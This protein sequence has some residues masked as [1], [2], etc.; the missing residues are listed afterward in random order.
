[1]KFNDDGLLLPN[2]FSGFGASFRWTFIQVYFNSHCFILN[3]CKKNIWRTIR[4]WR[5]VN[6][7]WLIFEIF[8]YNYKRIEKLTY[9]NYLNK[10][11]NRVSWPFY[12]FAPSW[13]YQQGHICSIYDVIDM[14]M[15]Y[16]IF[17]FSI[18]NY[19]ILNQTWY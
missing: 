17:P 2:M 9:F 7:H 4:L 18:F 10:S 1:M 14:I 13:W 8:N 6:I 5:H 3:V 12:F 15:V 11:F 16:R 19:C